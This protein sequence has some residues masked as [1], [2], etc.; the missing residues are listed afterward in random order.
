M[1]PVERRVVLRKDPGGLEP[2]KLEDLRGHPGSPRPGQMPWCLLQEH[3]G[4]TEG[5]GRAKIRFTGKNI[6][7][8]RAVNRLEGTG[9]RGRP[10]GPLPGS[11]EIRGQCTGAVS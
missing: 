10:R 5:A 2:R 9:A 1:N 6:S 8:C 4:D 11:G 3:W 7:S